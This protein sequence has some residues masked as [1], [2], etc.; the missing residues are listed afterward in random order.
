MFIPTV[1]NTSG[2]EH[3]AKENKRERIYKEDFHFSLRQYELHQVQRVLSQSLM[4]TP[5]AA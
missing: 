2:N 3:A 4:D 5:K 1:L